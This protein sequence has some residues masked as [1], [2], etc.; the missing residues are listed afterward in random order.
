MNTTDGLVVSNDTFG[1]LYKLIWALLRVVCSSSVRSKIGK[2]VPN[3][4]SLRETISGCGSSKQR[5]DSVRHILL[6]MRTIRVRWEAYILISYKIRSM[7]M[8]ITKFQF[9]SVDELLNQGID[10]YVLL[11]QKVGLT[12]EQLDDI[13]E[14]REYYRD[15]FN[16]EDWNRKM[17][18]NLPKKKHW[19]QR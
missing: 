18:E 17:Q 3:G 16:R 14:N 19:W 8:S 2:N 4:I 13:L 15:K 11:R 6:M 9:K 12:A 7:V 1:A 10:D 5:R